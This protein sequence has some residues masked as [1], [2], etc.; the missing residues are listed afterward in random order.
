VLYCNDDNAVYETGG[1]LD[2][3]YLIPYIGPEENGLNYYLV[4]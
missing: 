4:L 3:E 2:D 1:S